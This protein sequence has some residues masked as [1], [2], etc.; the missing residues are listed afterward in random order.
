MGETPRSS[1]KASS[2]S[3]MQRRE[4]RADHPKDSSAPPHQPFTSIPRMPTILSPEEA[5]ARRNLKSQGT[6]G[7]IQQPGDSGKRRT[8]MDGTSGR[9][10]AV[11]QPASPRKTSPPLQDMPLSSSNGYG[12]DSGVPVRRRDQNAARPLT[13]LPGTLKLPSIGP[14]LKSHSSGMRSPNGANSIR[15]KSSES[16]ILSTADM[17]S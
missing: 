3:R 5:T 8:L 6:T 7:P 4:V 13:Q 16:L 1:Q 11:G 14:Y 2:S 17:C 15:T 9:R 12:A 10:A